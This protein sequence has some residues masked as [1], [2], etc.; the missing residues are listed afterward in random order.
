M[1]NSLV[2]PKVQTLMEEAHYL[3]LNREQERVQIF[4]SKGFV[5]FSLL[6]LLSYI[7]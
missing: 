5:F 6:L 7:T 3:C 1:E 2:N 4:F